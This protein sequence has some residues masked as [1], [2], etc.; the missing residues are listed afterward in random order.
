VDNAFRSR[1]HRNP[2]RFYTDFYRTN[3]IIHLLYMYTRFVLFIIIILFFFFA[4]PQTA[5]VSVCPFCCLTTVCIIYNN[6]TFEPVV[7]LCF[8]VCCTSVV[9]CISSSGHYS[10]P[11]SLVECPTRYINPK[12]PSPRVEVSPT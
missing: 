6:H 10:C 12:T 8:L 9:R 11:P 2:D 7:I 4:R 5:T 3:V 1:V